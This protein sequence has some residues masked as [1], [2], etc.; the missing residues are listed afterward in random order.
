MEERSEQASEWDLTRA[1]RCGTI[2]AHAA[3]LRNERTWESVVKKMPR[4]SRLAAIEWQFFEV[5]MMLVAPVAADE[6]VGVV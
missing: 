4:P 2:G 3:A 5:S 6:S 1:R